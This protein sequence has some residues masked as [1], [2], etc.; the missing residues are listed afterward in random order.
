MKHPGNVS[1][2]FHINPEASSLEFLV[3][4]EMF[5][6]LNIL[7]EVNLGKYTFQ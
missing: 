3:A 1:S 2:I 5:P 4:K 7:F 6:E